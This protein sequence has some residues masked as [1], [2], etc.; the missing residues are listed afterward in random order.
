MYTSELNPYIFQLHIAVVEKQNR[1]Q[2]GRH[3]GN[4]STI[5]EHDG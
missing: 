4:L 3:H 1:Q 5:Y 2:R